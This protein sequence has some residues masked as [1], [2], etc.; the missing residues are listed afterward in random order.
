MEPGGIRV[1]CGRQRLKASC[2]KKVITRVR[3]LI[4]RKERNQFDPYKTW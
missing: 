4:L 3:I 2:R 1:T